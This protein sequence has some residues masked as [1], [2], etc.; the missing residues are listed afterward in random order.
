M[1][2]GVFDFL[3]LVLLTQVAHP[4]EIFLN[5]VA[6]LRRSLAKFLNHERFISYLPFLIIIA[7]SISKYLLMDSN[8][9]NHQYALFPQQNIPPDTNSTLLLDGLVSRQSPPG[10][11]TSVNEKIF[12]TISNTFIIT[13]SL[14]NSF[15]LL[16]WLYTTVY[17][18]VPY[19][20]LS[21][22][23]N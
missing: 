1:T 11:M 23:S 4:P 2:Y 12:N 17:S 8:F 19:D 14:V 22:K 13:S 15:L 5:Y 6:F 9:S 20:K 3:N 18:N 21:R 16:F 7:R 10:T